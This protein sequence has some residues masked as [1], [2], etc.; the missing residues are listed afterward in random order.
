MVLIR[1]PRLMQDNQEVTG[2]TIWIRMDRLRVKGL[3][4]NG[5]GRVVQSDSSGQNILLGNR[6]EA[7]VKAD[8]IRKV[9]IIGQA[10]NTYHVAGTE[11]TPGVNTLTGDHMVLTFESG[12]LSEVEVMSEPSLS[13]GEFAP[14][15]TVSKE[16]LQ[17]KMTTDTAKG[18]GPVSLE[19]KDLV[20][21]FHGRNVVNHVSISVSQG[22]VVDSWTERRG[23]DHVVLHDHGHD[24]S[25]CGADIL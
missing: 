3:D 22:E 2:D 6:I 5:R 11:S 13:T 19:S 25:E 4:V 15:S 12:K 7:E 16:T 10:Q 9:I 24:S 18:T 21:S 20:K 23:E 14:K 17:R 8:T 1:N